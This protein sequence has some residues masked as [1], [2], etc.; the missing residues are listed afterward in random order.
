MKKHPKAKNIQQHYRTALAQ[1]KKKNRYSFEAVAILTGLL[2]VLIFQWQNANKTEILAVHEPEKSWYEVTPH[3]DSYLKDLF[4]AY[5]GV[6]M[7][8]TDEPK[9]LI[10]KTTFGKSDEDIEGDLKEMINVANRLVGN[11]VSESHAE[12]YMI[13]VKGEND[14][15]LM[16]KVFSES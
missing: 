4:P 15:E 8:I 10:L 6:A 5:N 9:R 7:D 16:R 2:I 14:R 1:R 13:I 3:I 12:N 11:T